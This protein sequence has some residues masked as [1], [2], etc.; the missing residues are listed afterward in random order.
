VIGKIGTIRCCQRRKNVLGDQQSGSYRMESPLKHDV[1]LA[2]STTATTLLILPCEVSTLENMSDSIDAARQLLESR[3]LLRTM[4]SVDMS[5]LNTGT[6]K[7]FMYGWEQPSI[8]NLSGDRVLASK[9]N[10]AASGYK[11]KL[12]A[13]AGRIAIR[14]ETTLGERTSFDITTKE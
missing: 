9:M 10:S 3:L 8:S 11:E 4:A 14:S 13:Q 5:L 7:M 12:D 6:G 1:C 2:F